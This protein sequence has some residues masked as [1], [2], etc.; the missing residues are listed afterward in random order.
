LQRK[1]VLLAV[2]VFIFLATCTMQAIEPVR[3]EGTTLEMDSSI[4]LADPDLWMVNTTAQSRAFHNSSSA[5]VFDPFHGIYTWQW[6]PYGPRIEDLTFEVIHA[7]ETAVNLMIT[8]E[9]DVLDSV[10]PEYVSLLEANGLTITNHTL[11]GQFFFWENNIV[12]PLSDIN[13]RKAINRLL[14]RDSILADSNIRPHF[15][16]PEYWLPAGSRYINP[17]TPLPTFNPEEAVTILDA[18]G[19]MQG[20]EP[21]PDYDATKP[22][23]AQYLRIDPETGGTLAPIEYTTVI[24]EESPIHYEIAVIIVNTLRKA[25]LPI[26]FVPRTFTDIVSNIIVDEELDD[27]QLISGLGLIYNFKW[28]RMMYE[29]TYSENLPIWNMWNFNNSEADYW[30]LELLNTPNITRIEEAAYSIQ[31]ILQDYEP[32]MP[33]LLWNRFQAFDPKLDGIINMPGHGA[34]NQWTFLNIHN[35]EEPMSGAI[36]W[37]IRN[38]PDELSPAT[39]DSNPGWTVL[40][41]IYDRLRVEHPETSEYVPWLAENWK[42]ESWTAPGDIPGMKITFWLRKDVYWHDDAPFT[43]QDVEFGLEYIKTHQLLE[44]RDAWQNLVDV[45]IPQLYTIETY[46]NTSSVVANNLVDELVSAAAMFPKHIWQGVTDPLSFRPWEESHPTVPGLTKLIGTGPF[47]FVNYD[48]GIRV[49]LKANPNYFKRAFLAGPSGGTYSNTVETVTVDI[50]PDA[51][52]EDTVIS[53]D[54]H[55]TREYGGFLINQSE[56]IVSYGVYKLE[57]TGTDFSTPVTITLSYDETLV[58]EEHLEQLLVLYSAD[59]VTW[60]EIPIKSV[61]ATE[62]T[63]TIEVDHFSLVVIMQ[64]APSLSGTVTD[65][66]TNEPLQ[67][68]EI[69]ILETGESATTDENGEYSF[70]FSYAGNY[71]VEMTVPYGYLTHDAVTKFV[72]IT[73]ATEVDF[74]LYQASWSGATVPRTIGFWKNWDKHYMPELM[75]T[76]IENVKNA[77][78][79]FNDLTIENIESFFKITRHSTMEEKGR[80]Q[81]LASW[82][83]VVSAQLGVD[84]QV[85]LTSIFGW[86]TVIA[87]DDGILTVDELLRQIDNYYTNDATLTKEQWEKIK[88]ILDALNNGHLFIT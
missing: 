35:R 26:N 7:E 69:S 8:G 86:E 37:R 18:A 24:P 5:G 38:E 64:I 30:A 43:A 71:T 15:E 14:D 73:G 51:L 70:T 68:V 58:D 9:L 1:I 44:F 34:N 87:D 39:T 13:M 47:Y 46:F 45:A 56:N 57:P 21:N 66:Y 75:T 79:L 50:P 81:L 3:A 88:D 25:G 83:N 48:P 29:L 63:L 76:F 28:P 10:R 55:P 4:Y 41:R 61:N 78:G 49:S 82:L 2:L 53:I 67:G 62:N 60:S 72:E 22:W 80:A 65:E 6:E 11:Q 42:I 36:T 54:T 74:T 20:T 23:S 85:D 84:V 59:G 52:A 12:Y 27:Y 33:L 19:Y 40:N 17:D 31:E 77:S 32:Y 16:K